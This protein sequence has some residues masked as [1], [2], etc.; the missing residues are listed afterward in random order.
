MYTMGPKYLIMCRLSLLALKNYEYP[1]PS[2]VGA[3]RHGL[4][5]KCLL[6]ELIALVSAPNLSL[7]HVVQV[8]T[9]LASLSLASGDKVLPDAG[10]FFL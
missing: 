4:W 8:A 2:F 6:L 9:P 10:I 1:V 5:S 7:L 3:A